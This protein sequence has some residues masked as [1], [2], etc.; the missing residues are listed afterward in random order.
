MNHTQF[1]NSFDACV[2][3]T[4]YAGNVGF[5]ARLRAKDGSER[6]IKDVIQLSGKSVSE[7]DLRRMIDDKLNEAKKS[8]AVRSAGKIKESEI[9]ASILSTRQL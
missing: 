4:N 2:G 3:H 1:T 5:I 9:D 6:E 8:L 7:S